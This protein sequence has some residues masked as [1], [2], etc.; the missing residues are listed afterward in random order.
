MS[1]P[2][3]RLLNTTSVAASP[4]DAFLH[5]MRDSASPRQTTESRQHRNNPY[6]IVR[7]CVVCLHNGAGGDGRW[8]SNKARIRTLVDKNHLLR[9][10]AA[11]VRLQRIFAQ[12]LGLFYRLLLFS[13]FL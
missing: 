10:A 4:S 8:A 7:A 5:F 1:H 11:A 3:R 12:R 2:R 6:N 13:W 9:S